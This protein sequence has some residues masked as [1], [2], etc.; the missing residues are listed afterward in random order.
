[1]K[2]A[3]SLLLAT[4]FT[5][6]VMA[7]RHADDGVTVIHTGTMIDTDAGTTRTDQYIVIENGKIRDLVPESD[8]RRLDEPDHFI[9]LYNMTV[10]SGLS[11]SYA[12]LIGKGSGCVKTV[13]FL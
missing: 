3:L 11:G 4:S 10:L 12:H 13:S 8:Y 9:N 6:P 5:A 7:N 1:M 2:L